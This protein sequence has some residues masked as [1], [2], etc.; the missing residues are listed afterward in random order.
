MNFKG[1][2][3]EGIKYDETTLMQLVNS[4]YKEAKISPDMKNTFKN[5]GQ[6]EATL[7]LYEE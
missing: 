2:N 7:I 1:A 6:G 3:L 5:F 4:N